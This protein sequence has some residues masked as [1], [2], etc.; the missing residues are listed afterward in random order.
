MKIKSFTLLILG[1]ISSRI[2]PQAIDEEINHDKSINSYKSEIGFTAGYNW[3]SLFDYNKNNNVYNY[4]N[5]Y[6]VSIFYTKNFNHKIALGLTMENTA[7]KIKTDVTE[8]TGYLCSLREKLDY[9]IN[10]L[11]LSFLLKLNLINNK[12]FNL[13][14]NLGPYMGG[15]VYSKVTGEVETMEYEMLRDTN[16]LFNIPSPQPSSYE[17][18]ESPILNSFNLLTG[19]KIGY[20]LRFNLEDNLSILFQNNFCY[21]K[22]G[23]FY[24]LSNGKEYFNNISFS[25]GMI[26]KFGSN[27]NVSLLSGQENT[28][29]QR[30]ENKK[31]RS[32][33][34]TLAGLNF[35]SVYDKDEKPTN[36]TNEYTVS[37]FYKYNLVAVFNL[38]LAVNNSNI[39]VKS[40][41]Y[42]EYV[43]SGAMLGHFPGYH[44]I[45]TNSEINYI[46]LYLLIGYD[47]LNKE[48]IK[49]NIH[50][51]PFM[52][53]LAQ[54]RVIQ[55][56]E[57]K[58]YNS[59]WMPQYQN[60]FTVCHVIQSQSYSSHDST[61]TKVN[62][63]INIGYNIEYNLLKNLSLIFSNNYYM[64]MKDI[65]TDT[66][67]RICGFSFSLGIGYRF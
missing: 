46:N 32:E 13:G 60:Y 4:D 44:Y 65:K 2:Y 47:V 30:Q 58:V 35:I 19:F 33:F 34:G 53:F 62:Y 67:L 7:T 31:Y 64:N 1:L 17:V 41:N 15:I 43:T 23:N 61:A 42:S 18:D 3:F 27:N 37:L 51:D 55:N 29:E 54:S 10:Y 12:K 52:T 56:K 6:A 59:V 40:E 22:S 66:T 16:Y 39:K 48:K 26:Y 25:L 38:G 11:N 21:T 14:L 9:D 36:F 63:G 5:G 24:K 49:I 8:K 45:T 28:D 50:L 57:S 20:D